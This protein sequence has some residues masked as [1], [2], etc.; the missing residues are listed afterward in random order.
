MAQRVLEMKQAYVSL[1]AEYVRSNSEV[2]GMVYKG[3]RGN[4]AVYYEGLS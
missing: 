2:D 3:G 1:R 4:I